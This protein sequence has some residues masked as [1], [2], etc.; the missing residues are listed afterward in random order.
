MTPN[1][2]TADIEG[3]PRPYPTFS[4]PDL[5]AYEFPY[6]CPPLNFTG[7]KMQNRS[8]SQVEY[9]NALTWQSNPNN[10]DLSIQKYR[11]YQIKGVRKI[12]L[13]ELDINTFTYWHRNVEKAE[14]YEYAICAVNVV[15]GDGPLSFISV[16]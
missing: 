2:P 11:I 4:F 7:Q 14:H 6:V 12:L 3:N 9:V 8:F 1:V 16:Q 10:A 5:G 13:E 15:G